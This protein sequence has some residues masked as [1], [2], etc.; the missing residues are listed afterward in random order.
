MQEPVSAFQGAR[1]TAARPGDERAAVE[2]RSDASVWR[3]VTRILF[4][5]TFA[6][7]VLYLFPFPLQHIPGVSAVAAKYRELWDVLVLWVGKQ[8][9]GLEIVHRPA[10][11]GDTT[12]NYVQVF[13]YLV[14]AAA[15]TLVW[16]LLDRNRPNYARLHEWLRVYVRFALAVTLIASGASKVI[17][18]QFPRPPLGRLLESI[19]DASPLGLFSTFLGASLIYTMFSG[20]NEMIGGLLFAFRRTTSLG[21]LLCFGVVGNVVALSMTY[22]MP[23][24]LLS[25]H[26]LLMAVFLLLP[27]LRRLAD[28]FV[29]NREVEPAP[30][31]PLFA[32]PELNRAAR[33]L[34]PVFI[35]VLTVQALYVS[36]QRSLEHG[37]LAPKPPLYG[38]WE[39]EELETDGRVRPPLVTDGERW[40]WVVF[41]SPGTMGIQRMNERRVVYYG[42]ALDADARR[43]SL[44][45]ESD[46]NWKSDLVFQPS[47]PGLIALEGTFGGQKVR[48]RLRRIDESKF[49][50]VA[51][52]IDWINEWPMHPYDP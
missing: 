1:D 36:Y 22:D 24:K 40:R 19:G 51:P 35:A 12:Y 8:A 9:F 48:A 21:A 14:L 15:A 26:L 43:L 6:Y 16:T 29:L 10:G 20:L 52:K 34:G 47:G 42:L 32:R 49:A 3:P 39:V 44:S 13:C 7:L 27:D 28:L 50:L 25:S 41:D 45:K 17:P 11:S 38:I 33:I 2:P 23:A 37:N 31:R 46:P 4:R 18:S 30:I 5:F